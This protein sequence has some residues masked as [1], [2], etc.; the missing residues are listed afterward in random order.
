[1]VSLHI[2]YFSDSLDLVCAW[3]CRAEVLADA[4]E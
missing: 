3:K 1:M 4:L 2:F